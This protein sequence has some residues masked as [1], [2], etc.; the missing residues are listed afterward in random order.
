MA[1][2]WTIKDMARGDGRTA[3]VTGANSGLGYQTSVQLAAHG[4]TVIMACRDSARGQAALDRVTSEVPNASIELRT[5]DLAS[6]ASVRDFAAGVSEPVNVLVNNAGVM[7]IPHRTT[8]DGFEMQFGTNHLGHFALTGLLLPRLLTE[9]EPRVVTVSST[10]HRT[11]K[12]NFTD[13]QSEK[14]YQKWLAYGQ[15]KLANLLFA[16]ELGRRAAA[17]GTDLISVAAHPGYA[18]TNL[19]TA[20]PKMAGNRI[21]EKLSSLGN[22]IFSQ[23]DAQG[24]LPTLC[25][26]TAPDVASGQYYGPAGLF[27]QRGTG[28]KAVGRSK[29]AADETAA[30]RLWDVS[31]ELTGVRYD[32]SPAVSG[33]PGG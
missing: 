25:A 14:R 12:I 21:M 8:A 23:S 13:L 9:P 22:T 33:A 1:P 16:S 11:G 7:A 2:H 5:L 24:A 19:Q 10:M 20:G 26:A 6:L 30:R 4:Y 17:A 32:F 27:E 29:R 15:S 18:A 28:V 31:E 3:I